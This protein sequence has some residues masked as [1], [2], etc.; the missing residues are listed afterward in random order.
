MDAV[1]AARSGHPGTPMA[2][3]PAAYC[4]WH[5]VL[6]FDPDDPIWPNRDRFVLS[7]TLDDIRCFRQLDGRSLAGHLRLANLCWIHDD[8][9]IT[10][11]GATS[12]AFTEDV[13]ARFVAYGWNVTRVS[14]ANDRAMLDRSFAI[15]T[16]AT[17]RPTLIIMELPV[18]YIFTHD[19]IGVGEDGPTHQPVEHLASLRAIPG[20]ILFEQQPAAYRDEVLPPAVKARAANGR[21]IQRQESRS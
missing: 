14:D 1:Q 11:E 3:A 19:S 12:L 6:R 21:A 16:A 5:R 17:D 7:V 20:L 15:F 10:I 4:L 8:N 13:G 9:R 18:V 2:M